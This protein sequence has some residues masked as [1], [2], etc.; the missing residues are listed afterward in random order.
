MPVVTRL[1]PAPFERLDSLLDRTWTANYYPR[2]R[3]GW[4]A[5]LRPPSPVPPGGWEDPGFVR[6]ASVWTGLAPRTLWACTLHRFAP[7]CVWPEDLAAAPPADT[8]DGRPLWRAGDRALYVADADRLCPA[9]WRER[10]VRLLPW[11]LRFI[12]TCPWHRTL[13]VDCCDGCGRRIYLAHAPDACPSCR[14]VWDALPA[15]SVAAHAPSLDLS[16]LLW[17][18][19]GCGAPF[20]PQGL[21][22]SVDHPLRGLH[23]ATVLLFLWAAALSV[24]VSRDADPLDDAPDAGDIPAAAWRAW[25]DGWLWPLAT[26]TRPLR[27]VGQTHAA[28]IRVWRRIV[29]A[30]TAARD[31]REWQAETEAVR[32]LKARH[33]RALARAAEPSWSWL[34]GEF[35]RGEA[36]ARMNDAGSMCRRTREGALG[37]MPAGPSCP[38]LLAAR[39]AASGLRVGAYALRL[40]GGTG[41]VRDAHMVPDDAPHSRLG[42]LRATEPAGD[43]ATAALTLS[44]A[45]DQCG[46]AEAEVVALVAAGF[47]VAERGPLVDGAP[48]YAFSRTALRRFFGSVSPLT[49][50][51]RDTDLIHVTLASALRQLGAAGLRAPQV[52]AG[53]RAGDLPIYRGAFD[54]PVV[55]TWVPQ[56]ELDAYR[57][58]MASLARQPLLSADEV[59]RRLGCSVGAL[60]RL[61]REAALAPTVDGTDGSGVRWSYA[62]GEVDYTAWRYVTVEDAAHLLGLSVGAVRR[63]IAARRLTPMI[64]PPCDGSRQYR[65]D[66]FEAS[67]L[68]PAGPAG[69]VDSW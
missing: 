44:E 52:L 49:P 65:L 43:S 68:A 24:P 67:R 41:D 39:E 47:L 19:I 42:A 66:R 59:R 51:P 35:V 29:R 56:H 36:W 12:T 16:T 9:C 4:R 8:I 6:R 46:V 30:P 13:L 5:T 64:G 3:Q 33:G 27:A 1:Y 61:Y 57:Q 17:S 53:I 34:D 11:S 22:L 54:A 25:S 28:L 15:R 2:T 38:P 23:S 45:A 60:R 58:S 48:E 10:R 26:T 62:E 32:S 31:L 20:P 40:G 18:A 69:A 55:S 63:L 50:R 37:L 14:R 21:P 7:R